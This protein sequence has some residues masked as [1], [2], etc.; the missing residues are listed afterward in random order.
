MS[1]ETK[2]SAKDER[3]QRTE[4]AKMT[5]SFQPERGFEIYIQ[6]NYSWTQFASRDVFTLGGVKCFMPK[7][8]NGM[9]LQNINGQFR[10]EK[11][12]FH[13]GSNNNLNLSILLAVNIKEGVKFNFGVFPITSD[14]MDELLINFKNTVKMIYLSYCKP[15]SKSIIFTTE[16]IENEEHD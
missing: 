10:T 3:G 8:G 2:V 9:Q 15:V 7:N 5:L 1:N 6:S 11:D 4:L 12:W 14:K 16:T 13:D